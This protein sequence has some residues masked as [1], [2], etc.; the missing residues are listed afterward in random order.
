MS[1]FRFIKEVEITS[2]VTSV[3]LHNVFD[4]NFDVYKVTV[5]NVSTVGIT[6]SDI[7]IRFIQVDGVVNTEVQYNYGQ[8][9][10][11]SEAAFTNIYSGG[12]TGIPYALGACNQQPNTTQGVLHIFNPAKD[13][14]TLIKIQN[15]Y[16]LGAAV[17][18][19]TPGVAVHRIY[20]EMS[21]ISIYSNNSQPLATGK[22]RVYG[23]R[24]VF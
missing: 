13:R 17:G 7:G 15:S 16:S 11:K 21:G 3:E 24:M 12:D 14:R 8:Q 22:I 4:S 9:V 6:N 18:R 2:G 5:D 1:D 20:N 19:A 10:Q 23:Y